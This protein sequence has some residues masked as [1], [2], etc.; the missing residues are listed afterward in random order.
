MSDV[1]WYILWVYKTQHSSQVT[2]ATVA[3]K[4]IQKW[5]K[6]RLRFPA[7]CEWNSFVDRTF[8]QTQ[9]CP[10]SYDQLAYAPSLVK[11]LLKKLIPVKNYVFVIDKLPPLFLQEY[12]RTLVQKASSRSFHKEHEGDATTISCP[13]EWNSSLIARVCRHRCA[14]HHI[15]PTTDSLRPIFHSV[16]PEAFYTSYQLPHMC[17]ER[18]FYFCFIVLKKDQLVEIRQHLL[19]YIC[20]THVMHSS[21]FWFR[22]TVDVNI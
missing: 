10:T 20:T 5:Q 3:L 4:F 9:L 14:Q 15:K 1:I 21:C 8:I 16:F 22:T 19:T 2:V 7:K 17:H 12:S 13:H 6:I 11:A 18:S